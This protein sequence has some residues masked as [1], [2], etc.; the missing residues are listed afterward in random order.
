MSAV[1]PFIRIKHR[2]L[3]YSFYLCRDLREAN[4][5]GKIIY[6]AYPYWKF[7]RYDL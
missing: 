7:G 6:S 5:Y 4:Y 1:I 3:S 2:N